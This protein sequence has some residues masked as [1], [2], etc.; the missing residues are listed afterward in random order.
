MGALVVAGLGQTRGMG[1]MA[2]FM[3]MGLGTCMAGFSLSK[4]LPVSS[5]LPRQRPLF[6]ALRARIR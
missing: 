3:L 2:L 4:S 6:Q 1:R 5:P